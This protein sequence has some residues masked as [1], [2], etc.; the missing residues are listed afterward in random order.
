MSC[1]PCQL[2]TKFDFYILSYAVFVILQL[3]CVFLISTC[4]LISTILRCAIVFH[5]KNSL[6]TYLIIE[7]YITLI[8]QLFN[9][10]TLRL[11][12]AFSGSSASTVV[13]SM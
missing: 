5:N 10:F 1:A 7:H 3:Y 12:F 4:V 13:L 11:F 2:R 6:G 8:K 9:D